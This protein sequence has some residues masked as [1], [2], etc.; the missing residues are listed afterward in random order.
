[1]VSW[2]SKTSLPRRTSAKILHYSYSGKVKDDESF[3]TAV[4]NVFLGDS[5]TVKKFFRRAVDALKLDG[6]LSFTDDST[7]GNVETLKVGSTS[8]VSM[9]KDVLP[10]DAPRFVDES[11]YHKFASLVIF[12]NDDIEGGE[13]V[14]PNWANISVSPKKGK[15]FLFTICFPMVKWTYFQI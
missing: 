6:S 10:T 3:S 1:M 9:G 5:P 7:Y 11:H 8:S 13:N 2:R 15:P 4:V 14:F 12:L